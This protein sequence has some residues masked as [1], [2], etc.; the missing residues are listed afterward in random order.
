MKEVTSEPPLEDELRH[1]VEK[2]AG[3]PLGPGCAGT[4]PVAE[5]GVH[6]GVCA[7]CAARGP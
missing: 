3:C 4:G 1:Q 5:G 6:A 7:P 2:W